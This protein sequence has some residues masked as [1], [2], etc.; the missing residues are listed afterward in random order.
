MNFSAGFYSAIAGSVVSVLRAIAIGILSNGAKLQ[1]E[2]VTFARDL[3]RVA[4][5]VSSC[6]PRKICARENA[7]LQV[8][9]YYQL[10]SVA[11]IC[12]C[13]SKR[14]CA[15]KIGNDVWVFNTTW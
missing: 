1:L 4:I 14:S 12:S 2:A 11:E 7:V 5:V 8:S 15:E 6:G 3:E 10:S 13:V 9:P